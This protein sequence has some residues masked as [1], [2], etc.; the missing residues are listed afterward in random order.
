MW[1]K[2]VTWCKDSETIAFARL[3]TFGGLLI[4]VAATFDFSPLTIAGIPTKQ[5][6][7]S[8]SVLFAQG[9]ITEVL[10]RRRADV[11]DQGRLR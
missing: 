10:R 9:L 6:I 1:G 2:I 3:Q 8:A 5:Q 7:I 11:D 4:G